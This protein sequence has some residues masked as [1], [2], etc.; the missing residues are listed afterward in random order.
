MPAS[1][2][3]N[4]K[5]T[6][7]VN[8]ELTIFFALLVVIVGAFLIAQA[9]ISIT[10]AAVGTLRLEEQSGQMPE[11]QQIDIQTIPAI[12]LVLNTTNISSNDTNTNLTAYNTTQTNGTSLK[13]IYSWLRNGTSLTFLNMPFEGV[14]GT[15]TNNGWDYSGH[16]SNA[17]DYGNAFWNATGGY[18]G[19]GAYKFDGTEDYLSGVLPP[20]TANEAITI[21]A[22][23]R[24]DDLT[25]QRI[26]I[27]K[28]KSG[29]CFGYGMGSTNDRLLASNNDGYSVLGSGIVID[30]WQYLAISYNASGVFGYI[31]GVLIGSNPSTTTSACAQTNYTIGIEPTSN[32]FD[33][34]GHID[35]LTIWNRSLSAE[36]INAL[37]NNKTK[38][39]VSQETM[40]GENWSI[41][42][43]PNNGT[44]DGNQVLSSNVTILN[45]KPTISIL[46]LNTTNI[47][48]NNTDVNLTAYNNASD[49]DNESVKVIYNWLK[50]GTSLAFLNMPF[51]MV[52]GTTNNNGWDYSGHGSNASDYGNAFWNSTGGHDGKGAYKFDGTEDYLSGVLPNSDPNASITIT[53]WV[54]PENLAAGQQII[55][56]KGKT[57]GDFGIAY[58]MAI[59]EN[60]SLR[61]GTSSGSYNLSIGG[62]SQDAWNHLAI[63][64]NSSGSYGYING[65]FR[66]SDSRAVYTSTQNNFTLGIL[67]TD[68]IYDYK[69][70]IDEVMIWNRSLSPEQIFAL[71]QNDT[72]VIVAQE[73]NRW[74]NWTVEATPNDGFEDGST[75]TSNNV[76]ILY[77]LPTINTLV[78]N[79]TNISSNNT[80]VNLTAYANASNIGNGSII[81]NWLENGTS[82]AFLN[83][84]FEGINLTSTNNGWDYSGHGSNA[85]DYGNAFWNSTGGHDGKGAY[86]FDGTEDYL[87]GVLPNSDPN[88]SIT[89]TAWVKPEN[90]AAGQQIILSKGKTG[91][92]FGIAYAMAIDE[93]GSL[94]GGTSSGSYNL[95]IGGISQDAWNH[96]AI[97]YNSSGSYGYINGTFRGSDS[98]AVY[99]STQNNF[100]LGILVTDNIYDYKGHIDEVMIWNR[101]LSPEQIFALS[102]NDTD[103]IVAQET[104]RWENWTVEA[105][106]NDGFEDGSTVTSNNVTIINTKPAVTLLILNTTGSGSNT[107][108]TNLTAYANTSDPDN[109]GVKV[110]YN[111][112]RNGTSLAFLNMPFERINESPTNNGW[113]YSGHGSNASDYGNAFWNSTGG[114]DGKGAYKF[115]GVEDYLS[116]VLPPVTANETVTITAWIRPD[117]LEGDPQTIIAVGKGGNCAYGMIIDQNGTLRG[118]NATTAVPLGSGGI[119]I[120]E[121]HHVAVVYNAS[122]AYGYVNGTFRGSDPTTILACAQTNYTIGLVPTTN[123]LDYKGHID[124]LMIWNRS[125]SPEQIYA[126][127]QNDTDII[128]AQETIAGENWTVQATPNDGFEDGAMVTSNNVT[129]LEEP[130]A[131]AGVTQTVA[132]AGGGGGGGGGG[133]TTPRPV[134]Q[135]ACGNGIRENGEECDLG[136]GCTSDCEC[137]E[138]YKSV[139][140]IDCE[141]LPY[142]GDEIVNTPTEQCDG[143]DLNGQTCSLIGYADGELKCTSRCM[144]DTTN[145]ALPEE[146]ITEPEISKPRETWTAIKIFLQEKTEQVVKGSTAAISSIAGK[147]VKGSNAIM[148]F[149]AGEMSK[150]KEALVTTL[151]FIK[152]TL[153]PIVKESAAAISSIAGKM[154][155]FVKDY[156]TYW[157][158]SIAVILIFIV[159][160]SL[161]YQYLPEFLWKIKPVPQVQ[162]E[163]ELSTISS[164]TLTEKKDIN[165]RDWG[166]KNYIDL[167]QE[168]KKVEAL[169]K[170]TPL[171][172][173]KNKALKLTSLGTISAEQKQ[174]L[175]ISAKDRNRVQK[176]S[177]EEIKPWIEDLFAS[178]TPAYKVITIVKNAT[179]LSDKEIKNA[180]VKIRARQLLEKK[181]SLK[182]KTSVELQRFIHTERKKGATREQIIA[183]LAKE[184]WDE[185]IIRLYVSAHYD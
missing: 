86:K 63:V 148:I 3:T 54:K 113:D 39:I 25:G 5:R 176:K 61:G 17:S 170:E 153:G 144:I 112:L 58:A 159:G 84:P 64:Y 104:N 167:Q 90:L 66:G 150:A 161:K 45:A 89:I 34:K 168:L 36:Q 135:Y 24:L 67:V 71:S 40:R 51:E 126:L 141:R 131:E 10:G 154:I 125:L 180:L 117:R 87:S 59:D 46:V 157:L 130:Q 160:L 16:G 149:I 115:D 184:G 185:G 179:S 102:Q 106:P 18:D 80:N 21:T 111:W 173:Q 119:I 181:Y 65:T 82:L 69:G 138:G 101:S 55:L 166:R 122:G 123:N 72:D 110:I 41:L 124:E 151:I 128:V 2:K 22:W 145:C 103:V 29:D 136:D 78:L 99:T 152:D 1:K 74:E 42:A 12:T 156:S 70:H 134:A 140:E 75:V 76:T 162:V 132:N 49:I 182:Q 19:K 139:K 14:N 9:N 30:V 147:M 171:P 172:E 11:I 4:K 43:T 92:D 48:S 50:N 178:G 174:L 107:T 26:I 114:Y 175:E 93:N 33:F 53:A 8:V 94:R 31:N 13:V 177:I 127:S 81:Y 23:V 165:L 108:N 183:D 52:N 142:C 28:G 32:N 105:T 85:S 129:I 37:F 77:Q 164:P 15:A 96:L 60:G 35:E 47:S 91:G 6:R 146:T 133:V 169:I 155:K 27:N 38:E 100:T 95:S 97:V 62:I 68:N 116:G 137:D 143:S 73:T 109:G 83:M 158:L 98:R 120:D 88:A 56:S 118:A 7:K 121:W 57:G 79:T 44:G 163:E 20:T